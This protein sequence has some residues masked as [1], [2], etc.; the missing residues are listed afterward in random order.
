MGTGGDADDTSPPL[1]ATE[2]RA[3]FQGVND[4]VFQS[5]DDA[6]FAHDQ[7]DSEACQLRNLL[8]DAH[9]RTSYD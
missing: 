7:R 5:V 9:I 2:L 8:I 1:T 3:V 6:V 4:A